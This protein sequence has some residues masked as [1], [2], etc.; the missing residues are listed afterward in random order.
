MIVTAHKRTRL[1]ITNGGMHS[2]MEAIVHGV[3]IVGIALFGTDRY[4][5]AKIQNKNLGLFLEI[6]Q[7]TENRLY[8]LVIEALQNPRLVN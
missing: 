7:L 4:N 5:L 3:P 2:I 6:T 8:Q 1:L